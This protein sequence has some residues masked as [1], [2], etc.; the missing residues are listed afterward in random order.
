MVLGKR[1]RIY[2]PG[3]PSKRPRGRTTYRKRRTRMRRRKGPY[4]KAARSRKNQPFPRNMLVPMKSYITRTL[5]V[6]FDTTNFT[7]PLQGFRLN[8][9]Y[10]PA[11]ASV[12]VN[13]QSQFYDNLRAIYRRWKVHSV[14]VTIQAQLLSAETAASD[15]V[16]APIYLYYAALPSSQQNDV[17]AGFATADSAW[18]WMQ[19]PNI[20][21]RRIY[22]KEAKPFT[23]IS[24]YHKIKVIEGEPD[25]DEQYEGHADGLISD[26]PSRV[27]WG[28]LALGTDDAFSTATPFTAKLSLTVKLTFY[29][30]WSE[31]RTSA[32][33]TDQ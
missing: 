15:L 19:R 27:L 16:D 17:F 22:A 4:K 6:S 31:I 2:G 10:N 33:D 11:A 7:R 24:S 3:G 20:K 1:K 12:S 18:K 29:T 28:R 14:K 5:E 26:T 32:G 25:L 21:V 23:L 9:C 8:D 13:F 30:Q